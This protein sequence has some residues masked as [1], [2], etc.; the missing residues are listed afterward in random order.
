MRSKVRLAAFVI[1]TMLL[2]LAYQAMADEVYL[3]NGD[4]ITG[5]IETSEDGLLVVKTTYAKE[6]KVK[7]EEVV[8]VSSDEEVTVLLKNNEKIVGRAACPTLGT[9]QLIDQKNRGKEG[10]LTCR[11]PADQSATTSPRSYLQGTG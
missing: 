3:K 11:A 2:S 1:F 4:F 9:I 5:T 10:F 7:W 6:I 8:C